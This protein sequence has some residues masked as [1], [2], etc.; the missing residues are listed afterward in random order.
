[1]LSDD[2]QRKGLSI[3]IEIDPQ[4]PSHLRGDP[5]RIGQILLNY[6]NNAI[7]FSQSGT[8]HIRLRLQH[9]TQKNLQLYAEV[10]DQ[11]IGIPADHII[12]LFKEFQQADASITR[13]FGGTGLGLAISKKLATLMQGDVGVHSQEDQGSTFWFTAAVAKGSQASNAAPL[14]LSSS[15]AVPKYFQGLNIL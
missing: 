1:M 12:H 6:L 11:G 8:I 7:K 15:S 2:A 10:E 5:T 9:D 3:S 14:A 4:L 13:R